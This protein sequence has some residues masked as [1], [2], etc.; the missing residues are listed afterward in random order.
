LASAG[1]FGLFAFSSSTCLFLISLSLS[2]Y[3]IIIFSFLL[4]LTR[5]W[6][7]LPFD[8]PH[9]TNAHTSIFP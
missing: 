7:F 8:S 3:I 4:F 2:L 9:P 1:L 5:D 6:F